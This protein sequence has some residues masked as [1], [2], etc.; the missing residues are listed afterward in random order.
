L[1]AY[2][3]TGHVKIDNTIVLRSSS[4]S[5]KMVARVWSEGPPKDATS[6]KLFQLIRFIAAWWWVG[7][8]TF[9]RIV[10][11]AQKLFFRKNLH[12]WYRPEVVKTSIGRAYTADEEQLEQYFR[13]FIEDAV[14]HAA[15]PLRVIYQPAHGSAEVAMYSPSFTY[16]EDHMRTLTIRV[17]TPAFYSRFVHYAHTSEAFDREGLTTD[18]KNRTI[19]INPAELLPLFLNGMKRSEDIDGIWS[20]TI[21]EHVRWSL[22]R[23]LRCPPP[24]E[25]YSTSTNH[26]VADIRSFGEAEMDAFLRREEEPGNYLR[27]AMKLFLATRFTF[28]LP[29]IV[30]GVDW[31]FRA[32]MILASMHYSSRVEP[33]D[34]FRP[35]T[36]TVD[37][38]G[39]GAILFVL[40]NGVHLWSRLKHSR[41]DRFL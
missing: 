2:E 24:T 6:I 23:R 9:P 17:T 18:E 19:I 34:V 35:R 39:R 7:L 31:F 36:F 16:E 26:R 5:A 28:G 37:D 22:L 20:Q 33:L 11:E 1:A 32:I 12:V 40:A 8:L 4:D 14:A 29:V 13:A 27:I 38:L 30:E 10:W 21:V 15:K 25:S 3:E 41:T